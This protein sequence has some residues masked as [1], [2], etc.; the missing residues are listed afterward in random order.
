MPVLRVLMHAIHE[1]THG[2]G[3]GY[4]FSNGSCRESALLSFYGGNHAND[5]ARSHAAH[6][7]FSSIFQGDHHFTFIDVKEKWRLLAL[8]DQY[9]FILERAQLTTDFRLD[10]GPAFQNKFFVHA[11]DSRRNGWSQAVTN[12]TEDK[13][14]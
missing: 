11:A 12:V 5:A 2:D 4:Y 10:R 1:C 7:P 13:V 8:C 9:F 14:S 3:F 6:S